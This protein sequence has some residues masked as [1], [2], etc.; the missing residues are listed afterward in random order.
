MLIAGC[1]ALLLGALEFG[2]DIL[3]F[4]AVFAGNYKKTFLLLIG[5]LAVY[6]FSIWLVL[7]FFRAFLTAAGIGFGAGF[8]CCILL[9]GVI[10]LTRK[11]G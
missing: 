1:L 3:M 9:Y 11:N 8:L 5:K 10:K 6:A 7:Q 2:A 4:A